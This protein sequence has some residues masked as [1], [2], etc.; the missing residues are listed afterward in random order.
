M[1]CRGRSNIIHNPYILA[2]F[3]IPEREFTRPLC[4]MPVSFPTYDGVPSLAGVFRVHEIY[5][6]LST[7]TN[8]GQCELASRGKTTVILNIPLKFRI[9]TNCEKHARRQ[10]RT[11][12]MSVLNHAKGGFGI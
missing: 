5:I 10:Y 9:V 12:S 7:N 8:R 3:N 4:A 6:S 2:I 11:I 1:K